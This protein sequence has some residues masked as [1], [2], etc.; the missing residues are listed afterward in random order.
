MIPFH[1]EYSNLQ[2]I[3]KYATFITLYFKH[4][5]NQTMNLKS[6]I[7]IIKIVLLDLHNT[8]VG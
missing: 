4:C 6:I 8:T 5:Y 3:C 7:S 2:Y 1:T